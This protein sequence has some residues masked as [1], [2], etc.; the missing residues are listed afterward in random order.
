MDTAP[1]YVRY[2][3]QS[4]GRAGIAR[5]RRETDQHLGRLGPYTPGRE[6]CDKDRTAFQKV[7]ASRPERERFAAMLAYLAAHPGARIAAWHADR[8]IRSG[9]DAEDLIRVCAKGGH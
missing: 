6:F 5:Q 8:L 3:R 9:A 2:L 1:E 4:K 7:G